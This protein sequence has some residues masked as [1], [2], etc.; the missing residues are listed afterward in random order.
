M[1]HIEQVQRNPLELRGDSNHTKGRPH[2]G[3]LPGENPWHQD[4]GAFEELACLILHIQ[5]RWQLCT[6]PWLSSLSVRLTA[7]LQ[8]GHK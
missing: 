3:A 7:A 2:C 5:L 4:S 8:F 1:T 6:Y